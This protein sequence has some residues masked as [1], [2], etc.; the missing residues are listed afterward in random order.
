MQSMLVPPAMGWHKHAK[1]PPSIAKYSTWMHRHYYCALR[2]MTMTNQFFLHLAIIFTLADWAPLNVSVLRKLGRHGRSR[3]PGKMFS[4][5]SSFFVP[6]ISFSVAKTDVRAEIFRL[7]EMRVWHLTLNDAAVAR[8]I[9]QLIGDTIIRDNRDAP[10]AVENANGRTSG[11]SSSSPTAAPNRNKMASNFSP[12]PTSAKCSLGEFKLV[13]MNNAGN[14]VGRHEH[15]LGNLVIHGRPHQH[16]GD[17]SPALVPASGEHAANRPSAAG[18][19]SPAAFEVSASC[20]LLITPRGD[21]SYSSPPTTGSINAAACDSGRGPSA[22]IA[23]CWEM[24]HG[25]TGA[26]ADGDESRSLHQADGSEAKVSIR[27]PSIYIACHDPGGAPRP[28]PPTAADGGDAVQSRSQEGLVISDIIITPIIVADKPRV[29][30]SNMAAASAAESARGRG[31]DDS[32]EASSNSSDEAIN[33]QQSSAAEA[34][35]RGEGSSAAGSS[36]C[37][38]STARRGFRPMISETRVNVRAVG[39][40]L[41]AGVAEWLDLG[42]RWKHERAAATR[43]RVQAL[44]ACESLY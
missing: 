41:G 14:S 17:S 1:M 31:D 25:E 44:R 33:S 34:A 7:E 39:G 29:S 23:I 8:R 43:R 26:S 15:R 40:T 3:Q 5:K 24:L 28:P 6:T 36:P 37:E 27:I 16:S 42:A 22:A 21:T 18:T 19:E 10:V 9:R 4:V 38:P 12:W 30:G 20:P 13:L 11:V 2:K 32:K 35:S